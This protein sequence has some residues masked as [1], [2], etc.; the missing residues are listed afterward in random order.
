MDEPSEPPPFQ[1]QD[2]L[3]PPALEQVADAAGAGAAEEEEEEE[4]EEEAPGA[5]RVAGETQ[6]VGNGADEAGE[7]VAAAAAAA[8]SVP[9]PVLIVLPSALD[10]ATAP[11]DSVE[12]PHAHEAS[13]VPST[14]AGGAGSSSCPTPSMPAPV[15]SLLSQP[16][17]ISVQ[18][19]LTLQ[20]AYE[21]PQMSD[22]PP[23]S[24]Q[25]AK[26]LYTRQVHWWQAHRQ[27]V[28]ACA[29]LRW[30]WPRIARGA[31]TP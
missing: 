12:A 27:A 25:G 15:P 19:P 11:I 4:E 10:S 29:A 22:T 18:L 3:Q 30:V 21:A 13:A 7:A 17:R 31:C 23:V 28:R 2:L 24:E 8:V 5:A 9:T 26:D 14:S 6:P 20:M 16:R 1:A